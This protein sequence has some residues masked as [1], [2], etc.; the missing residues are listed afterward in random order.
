MISGKALTYDFLK[1]NFQWGLVIFNPEIYVADFGPLNRAFSGCFPKNL[2]H[3][4][5]ENSAVLVA[6]SFPKAKYCS[7][8]NCKIIL[9]RK[10]G[11]LE[12]G[13]N[14]KE[15]ISN[16]T[17]KLKSH[18]AC[19][20]KEYTSKRCANCKEGFLQDHIFH[21]SWFLNFIWRCKEYSF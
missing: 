15:K 13:S 9:L 3:W 21:L 2:H 17:K 10:A 4:F 16:I 18:K 7:F 20:A 6:S 12:F 1:N 11:V 8:N 14:T 19:Q 5:S